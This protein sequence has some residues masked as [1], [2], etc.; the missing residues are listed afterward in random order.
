MGVDNVE[1][2]LGEIVK[3]GVVCPLLA[4]EDNNSST[5]RQKTNVTTHSSRE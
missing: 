2:R 1:E 5:V 3:G 4:G